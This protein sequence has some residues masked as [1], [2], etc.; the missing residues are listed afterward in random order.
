ML[1][2]QRNVFVGYQ[3]C[4]FLL[5]Y[6]LTLIYNFMVEISK[7]HIVMVVPHKVDLTVY[8]LSRILK[9]IIHLSFQQHLYII[10]TVQDVIGHTYLGGK[11]LLC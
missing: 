5:G 1:T 6:Y 11:R 4:M 8:K 10:R 2:V 3:Y 7:Y 9:K